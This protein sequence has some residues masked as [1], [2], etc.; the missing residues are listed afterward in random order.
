L[1]CIIQNISEIFEKLVLK[2]WKVQ[3][4]E[5]FLWIFWFGRGFLYGFYGFG[6]GR[7]DFLQL[8]F[9]SEGL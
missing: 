9:Y 5:T 6:L 7:R 1:T 2:I 4:L 8:G 3:R